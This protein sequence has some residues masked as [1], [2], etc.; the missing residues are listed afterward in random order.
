MLTPVVRIKGDGA[1]GKKNPPIL[2]QS[3]RCQGLRLACSAQRL[4]QAEKTR[5]ACHGLTLGL[6]W[7][8]STTE[9][10]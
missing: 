5:M 6:V 3:V 8:L 1:E 9:A 4:C 7:V 10:A 2:G